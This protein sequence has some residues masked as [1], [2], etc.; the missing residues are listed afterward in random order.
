[1]ASVKIIDNEIA[2]GAR[3]VEESDFKVE[4]TDMDVLPH[5][6]PHVL[7]AVGVGGEDVGNTVVVV[8]GAWSDHLAVST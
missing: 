8:E 2:F 5:V 3:G 1:M 6:G 7:S 4:F